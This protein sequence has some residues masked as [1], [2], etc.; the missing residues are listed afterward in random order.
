MSTVL[1][2]Y[3]TLFKFPILINKL[4]QL[5]L[6]DFNRGKIYRIAELKSKHEDVQSSLP[7]LVREIT[8]VSFSRSYIK[9]RRRNG[10]HVS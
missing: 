10:L 9:S 8:E 3:D 1:N 5:Y 2:I 7:W 6:V 4:T